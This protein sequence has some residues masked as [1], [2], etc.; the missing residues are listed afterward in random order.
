MAEGKKLHARM[1]PLVE[2][3]LAKREAM[4]VELRPFVR[5]VEQQEV[6]A[7]EAK[8]GRTASWHAANV[9][10]WANRVVDTFPKTRPQQMSAE[11]IDEMMMGIGPDT[12]G[13]TFDQI[14][15]GVVPPKNVVIDMT[16]FD[17]AMKGYTEAVATF[18]KFAAEKH[19]DVE[20]LDDFKG[21]PQA[22]LAALRELQKPLQQNQGKDFE[23]S[24][25]LVNQVVQTYFDMFNDGNGPA[26]SQLRTLLE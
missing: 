4:L 21:K 26:Q 19:D 22:L 2:T 1:V 9:L 6:A 11:M 15:A 12:P 14:I 23:G 10:H 25:P 7:K 5:D 17:P 24:T 20:D 18:D 13:E 3:F 16:R 8:E